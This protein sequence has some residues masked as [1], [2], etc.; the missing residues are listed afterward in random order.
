MANNEFKMRTTKPEA[1]NKYY[2]TKANGGYSSAIKGKPTDSDCD[3]LSNCVGYAYGRFNE[4]G[5]YGYC[6]YLTPTNAEKFI[7]YK[8]SELE[9]GQTPKLGACMVWQKGDTLSSSDGA[10]H[11]AIVEKVV[12]DT[13]VYTS[14]SGYNASKPFWNQ[15][16]KKGSGNWGQDSNYKF[17]GFIYNPAVKESTVST[18]VSAPASSTTTSLKAGEKLNLN[19]ATVYSSST[20]TNSVSTKSG[21]YYVWSATVVNNRVRITNKTSNVGK[22][23]Q[24]TGWIS[25]DDAKKSIDSTTTTFNPYMVRVD[26]KNLNIRKGAG[27]NY[28]ICGSIKNKGTYTI[29]DE[30]TGSGATKWG[31]LKAYKDDRNGWISLDYC[32]KV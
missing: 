29:V 15:T 9:V 25:V 8:N 12:S 24:V 32:E 3:V 16:R 22:A 23:N 19:N 28:A 30:A 26:V 6:K 7:Q 31:L 11:V 27:T 10:G 4:I 14:E 18:N 13:E 1:G 20:S 17:L 5:R 21:T 2:I